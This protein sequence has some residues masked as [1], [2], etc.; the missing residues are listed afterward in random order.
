MKT[1]TKLF[2]IFAILT[3]ITSKASHLM[4]G[5]ISYEHLGNGNY[6]ILLT[7]FRDCDGIAMNQPQLNISSAC[8]TFVITPSL[9]STGLSSIYCNAIVSTCNGGSF[10]GYEYFVYTDTVN[11]SPCSD[12][13]IS[14]NECCRNAAPIN[15]FSPSSSEFRI[16][17]ILNN[18]SS[19][20]SSPV[21]SYQ[22]L[23]LVPLNSPICINNT[24]YDYDGDSIVYSLV[25]PTFGLNL[26]ATYPSAYS[27]T[28]PFG[29][30]A[31][32]SFNP[33]SGNICKPASSGYI[34]AYLIAIK[35]EEFRN[36]SLIGSVIRD[37][38]IVQIATGSGSPLSIDGVVTDAQNNPVQGVTVELYEYSIAQGVM[39]LSAT[40]TTN[41]SG[42]YYFGNKPRRQYVARVIPIDTTYL[43]TYHQ[44]TYF[45]NTSQLIFSFCDTLLNADINLVTN[46]NPMGTGIVAGYMNGLNIR[47]VDVVGPVHIFLIDKNTGDL[48]TQ[49]TIDV[50]GYYQFN[51]VPDGQ[52]RITADIAGLNM[53]STHYPI[54]NGGGLNGNFDFIAT[55]DGIYALPLLTTNSNNLTASNNLVI[56]PNPGNEIINI[57]TNNQLKTNVTLYDILGKVVQTQTFRENSTSISVSSLAKG[58]YYILLHNGDTTKSF[59]WIKE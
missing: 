47:T 42:Q 57:S 41:A 49:T 20:N 23:M 4:S 46:A 40:A 32:M 56:Y 18:L 44:S 2:F 1:I 5:E 7:L 13:K 3:S 36:G 55:P 12:W 10:P 39:P 53:L 34:G 16:E 52:Y 29:I 25:A 9:I 48:A 17:T 24:T 58:T 59:K 45:W 38:Q 27:A 54:V 21:F 14:Y 50:N 43:P 35:V 11:L 31:L 51:N 6:K 22:P 19:E 33:Q 15:V 30:G 28:D 26:P 37:I 8:S